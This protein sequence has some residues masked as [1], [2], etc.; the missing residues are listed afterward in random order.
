M[1]TPSTQYGK[2]LLVHIVDDRAQ[3]DPGRE[4]V[5]IPKTSSP[6]DGWKKITYQQA[7]NAVNRVAHKLVGSTGKP[8]NGEFPTVAY[9]GPNDVR[10]L[11]FTLGAVKAG[12][13]ALFI[14]P[15]NSQE[16]QLNLFGQ[17]NCNIIWF[18]G[19]YT[20]MVQPWLQERDMHAI[21]AFPVSAWFPEEHIE[22]YP[23]S[24]T[25]DEAE[26]D[27]LLVL[28]TSGSTGLPKP[29][30]ARQG[31]L[32]I[33]DKYHNLGEWKGRVIWVDG[34]AR[35]SK[36]ILHPMPLYH[37][38]ALYTSLFMVHYWDVPTALGI[39]IGR[40][41]PAWCWNVLK[42]SINVLKELAYVGFGGGNLSSEAGHRLVKNG[43]TILNVISA[44]E[45]TPY[46]IYWQPIPELW[47]YFIFNSELFGCDWRKSADGETYEQVVVGKHKYPGYQGFFYTFPDAKE[48]STKDLYKPHPSMADH[49][50]FYGRADNII[51]FSNGEKLNPVSIE[52]IMMGHPGI[53]GTIVVGSNRFQPAMIVPTV[54]PKAKKEANEFLDSIWP[55]V[56]KA[57]KETVAHGQIGRQFITLSNPSK[58]F[59]RAG[60]GTIQRAST[61][62]MYKNEINKIYEDANKVTSSE[63][64]KLDLSSKETLRRSIE[65][66][67]EKWLGAPTL[68]PDT[69][70]FTVGIDSMQV[71][72]ASRLL[73]AG[74]EA[75]GVHVDASALATRVIYGNPTT[76]RLAEYLYSV[77]NMESKDATAGEG[78]AQQEDH[79]MEALIEKI[80]G[81]RHANKTG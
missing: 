63:T 73:M 13:Q 54:Q 60:K 80:C 59:L 53:K 77:V 11:V 51:V 6:E 56:V 70:F 34:M 43:V 66:L 72:N 49:W 45:F 23:Y 18:D 78:Q 20:A 64:P 50:M 14:S 28:H 5:S 10:Y 67:F 12:Y 17:T 40:S 16:G 26:W 52:Q 15:R 71:I 41:H 68:E 58:P 62:R 7:A 76:K 75:A 37:A 48:Y 57:N 21:M 32:A 44:T 4:W 81:D 1:T 27:P 30:V 9:L 25:F 36:R 47:R 74:L 31:M 38:A 55:L 42:E 2:R 24:K 35:R 8:E 61:V 3:S 79:A 33:A 19:A 46:P 22:P 29:I 65:S 39:V 69:D